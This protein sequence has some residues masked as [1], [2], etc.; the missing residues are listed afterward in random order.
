MVAIINLNFT[1]MKKKTAMGDT[2]L[3]KEKRNLFSDRLDNMSTRDA[4]N[5][6]YNYYGYKHLL[7]EECYN[8]AVENGLIEKLW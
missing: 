6:L 7:S 4:L 3:Q 5:V 2:M 1:I 8:D